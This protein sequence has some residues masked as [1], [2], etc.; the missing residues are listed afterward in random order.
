[1][2]ITILT[3]PPG[4]K[5]YIKGYGKQD[6]EWE[7]IGS[8]PIDSI[9]MP[10]GLFYEC[11]IEKEGFESLSAVFSTYQD[12]LYRK[13]FRQGT[14]PAGMVPV[15]GYEYESAGDYLGD[16]NLLRTVRS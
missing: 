9:S 12:T 2:K 13:L 6:D 8:S 10:A 5:I 11:K 15:I 4:A 16:M 3:D 14:V 7:L 1:M